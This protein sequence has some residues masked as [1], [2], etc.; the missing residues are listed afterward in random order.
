MEQLTTKKQNKLN[1]VSYDNRLVKKAYQTWSNMMTR[2]Y[3]KKWQEK[4]PTYIGCSVCDEWHDYQVFAKWFYDNYYI[5][6]GHRMDLDKDILI[7]G[8]KIYSP[9]TCV[10]VP[11]FINALFIK[12]DANRGDLPLGVAITE[13]GYYL[14]QCSVPDV[15]L[16]HLGNYKTPK[17]AFNAYKE[18][19]E[20]LIKDIADTYK[21]KISKR[22]YDALYLYKVEITD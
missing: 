10:F 16:K 13:C 19:K 14:A 3:N 2:C 11:H 1:E 9:N 15:G 5:I 12:K 20:Q 22:L 21:D 18:F 4:F 7:K 17:E 8:N 6:N